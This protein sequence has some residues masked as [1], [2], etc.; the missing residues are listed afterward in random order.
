[1]REIVCAERKELGFTSNFVRCQ[2]RSG[3]LDHSADVIFKILHAG[4]A[5]HFVRNLYDQRLLILQFFYAA[6]QRN[7]DLGNDFHAFLRH[8][9]GGFKDGARL[10]LRYFRI[11]N[12]QAAAAMAKHRVELMQLFHAVQQFGQMFFQFAHRH[13]VR[14][15]QVFLLARCRVRKFSNIHHE[16]FALRQELMQRRIKRAD[17]HRESVHRLE[18]TGEILALHRQQLLQCLCAGL[19][20]TR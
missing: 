7:H 18:Q 20:V 13:T 19:F 5:Q 3:N 10:H 9:Y 6:D 2:R 14:S 15:G 17:H 8:L 4:S 1:M 12:A 16:G 11:G